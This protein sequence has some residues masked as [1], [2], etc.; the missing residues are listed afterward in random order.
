MLVSIAR[1]GDPQMVGTFALAQ[2]V[3]APIVLFG[4]LQLR[5][6]QATD[7]NERFR[8]GHYLALRYLTTIGAFAVVVVWALLGRY[9]AESLMVIVIVAVAKSIESLSDIYFGLLQHHEEMRRIAVSL[10]MKGLLS[11]G[12]LSGTLYLTH[13][14]VP[15][16]ATMMLVW[17]L[18]FSAYDS[19][20]RR[21]TG[22]VWD[23]RALFLLFHLALPLGIT[24]L[25]TSLN[26]NVPRYFME[27]FQGTRQLGLFSALTAVQSAG[28]L[29]VMALGNAAMPRMA[30]LYHDADWCGFRRTVL[31]FLAIALGLGALTLL[32]V[33]VA[34][35]GLI[36]RVFGREYAGRNLTFIWLA[37]AS[38]IGYVTSVFGYASTA[39]RRIRFQPVACGVMTAV[40]TL[41]CCWSVRVY[42]DL[43]AAITMCTASAVGLL[44][45]VGSFAG[46]ARE[47]GSKPKAGN[48]IPDRLS[49]IC[50]ETGRRQK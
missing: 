36:A 29:V 14:L 2:A 32:P 13:R 49:L 46:T 25:L 19:R 37:L 50:V 31:L 40:T 38:A 26:T 5:V 42:G 43:G 11:L 15:A 45:Y 44:L 39:A 8:F 1:L 6:I 48:R 33:L 41:G 27:H 30:R 34:G 4:N 17:L 18:V 9:R 22:P 35:D 16:A 7:S 21:A 24:T 3:T 10:I 23:R 20:A 47:I 28:M 12:V